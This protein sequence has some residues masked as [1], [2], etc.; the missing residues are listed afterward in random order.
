MTDKY[1]EDIKRYQPSVNDKA[2]AV[3]VKHL[4][5][6]L[7]GY[8]GHVATALAPTSGSGL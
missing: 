5:I 8:P 6:A 3:I 1:I 7:P 2:V 4:G